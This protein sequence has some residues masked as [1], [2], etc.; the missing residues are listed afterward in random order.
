MAAPAEAV[1]EL[2][3]ATQRVTKLTT[4]ARFAA[5]LARVLERSD[6]GSKLASGCAAKGV[7]NIGALRSMGYDGQIELYTA[8]GLGPMFNVT[9][10]QFLA[11]EREDAYTPQAPAHMG[12]LHGG[13]GATLIA[14]KTMRLSFEEL[15]PNIPKGFECKRDI[16]YLP[17][18]IAD[19]L[20]ASKGRAIIKVAAVVHA[21]KDWLFVRFAC[22]HHSHPDTPVPVEDLIRRI[23]EL[24][25]DEDGHGHTI[26]EGNP[27]VQYVGPTA[28]ELLIGK[29]KS[30]QTQ[31]RQNVRQFMQAEFPGTK[32]ARHCRVLSTADAARVQDVLAA[33]FGFQY[34]T[35]HGASDLKMQTAGA[36]GREAEEDDEAGDEAGE[37]G[38]AA[39][40]QFG[41]GFGAPPLPRAPATSFEPNAP[42]AAAA[43]AADAAAAAASV[44]Q[45]AQAT[46]DARRAQ[47]AKRKLERQANHAAGKENEAEENDTEVVSPRS[48]KTRPKAAAVLGPSFKERFTNTT[49]ATKYKVISKDEVLELSRTKVD[50]KKHQG[51]G[52]KHVRVA[53]LFKCNTEAAAAMK[54]AA[55][56]FG[57]DEDDETI[58]PK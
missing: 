18:M 26:F 20:P 22:V 44:R 16:A 41:G 9:I 3:L 40:M 10:N 23:A 7:V 36:G 19:A 48:K 33:G 31:D 28:V 11:Y 47:A 14:K 57:E 6:I 42:P 50:M 25:T 5:A 46:K 54:D 12:A 1:A 43:D 29:V 35:A 45:E 2:D 56:L 53:A 52:G 49:I 38:E 27:S 17:G 30:K 58:A 8:S 32:K 13:D 4:I 39:G 37:A 21:I 51:Y 24:I 55:E 15:V 34:P